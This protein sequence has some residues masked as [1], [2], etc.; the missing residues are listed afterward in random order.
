MRNLTLLFLP[1]LFFWVGCNPS[2]PSNFPSVVPVKVTVNDQGSPIDN[3]AVVFTV[4]DSGV[5][6]IVGG[7]TDPSGVVELKTTQATHQVKGCPLGKYKVTLNKAPKL[8]SEK[9]REEINR[10]TPEETNAYSQIIEK[11]TKEAKPI[12][13]TPLTSI[14]TTPITVEV[15]AGGKDFTFDISEYKK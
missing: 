9:T 8:P 10:M 11:E 5:S 7:N 6:H 15:P 13:P 14:T 12:I 4:S 2:V 1:F 3:V